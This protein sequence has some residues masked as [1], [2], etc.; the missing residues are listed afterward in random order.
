MNHPRANPLKGII[1]S[2][3]A[4]SLWACGDAAVKYVGAGVPLY[5]IAFYSLLVVVAVL[6]LTGL[7]GRIGRL[8]GVLQSRQLK[9][10]ALRGALGFIQF[11][12]VMYG[13]THISL[14]KAYTLLFSAPL[15]TALLASFLIGEKAGRGKWL[16]IAL[17]FGGVL[18]VLR[19]GLIPLDTA[20]LVMLLSATLFSLTNLVARHVGRSGQDALLV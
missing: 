6:F 9:W 12:T 11:L 10:H 20:A 15:L 7:T 3:A 4:F 5:T 19:P 18:I 2:L 17:G 13:F 1:L 14:A 8:D 16:A